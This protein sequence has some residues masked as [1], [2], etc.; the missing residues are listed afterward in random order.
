MNIQW[1]IMGV[2][3]L[4]ATVMAY[5]YVA[6]YDK[7]TGRHPDPQIGEAAK[8][9]VCLLWPVVTVMELTKRRKSND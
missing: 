7:W 4:L 3:Y 8:W 2:L 9:I 1:A 6:D 5:C